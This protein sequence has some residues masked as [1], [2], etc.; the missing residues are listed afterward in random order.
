MYIIFLLSIFSTNT[1]LLVLALG[2][3][4]A[5]D[6]FIS[7]SE[8]FQYALTLLYLLASTAVLLFLQYHCS[9]MMPD[10]LLLSYLL[11]LPVLTSTSSTWLTFLISIEWA[12]RIYLELGCGPYFSS[13][14]IIYASSSCSVQRGRRT[15]LA[16]EEAS[17]H[18]SGQPMRDQAPGQIGWPSASAP[19]WKMAF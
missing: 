2:S 9:V 15:S 12:L 11:Q 13:E 3:C 16:K 7:R 8:L 5:L 14:L 17:L 1:S 6:R 10:I 4:I 19:P 18:S